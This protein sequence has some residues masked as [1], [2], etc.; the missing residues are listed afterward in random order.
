[1]TARAAMEK[2]WVAYLKQIQADGD[3]PNWS[4]PPYDLYRG[5]HEE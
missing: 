2:R 1:M 3:F 5:N 4:G